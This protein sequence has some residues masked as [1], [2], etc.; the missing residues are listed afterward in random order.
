[1]THL[2]L[3]TVFESVVMETPGDITQERAVIHLLGSVMMQNTVNR[4]LMPGAGIL[5]RAS[6]PVC[7]F[8]GMEILKSMVMDIRMERHKMQKDKNNYM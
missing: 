6:F 8:M 5:G 4:V 1:M 3:A 2:A 7:A